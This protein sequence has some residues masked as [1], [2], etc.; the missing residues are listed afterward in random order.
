MRGELYLCSPGDIIVHAGMRLSCG[1][2]ALGPPK[3][4]CS[5]HELLGCLS[6]TTAELHL[7]LLLVPIRKGG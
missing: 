2:A 3:L 5:V 1:V 7:G 6:W 4:P